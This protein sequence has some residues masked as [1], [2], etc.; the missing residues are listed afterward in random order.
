MIACITVPYFAASVERRDD[1]ALDGRS[2]V[3]GGQPWEPRPVFAYSR[4]VA[5]EGVRP[6][7]SL[8]QAHALSPEALF[9]S[10]ARLRYHHA[11]GEVVD[12]LADF[13]GV[14][15]P[16]EVWH[17]HTQVQQSAS[18]AGRS[19][20]AHFYLDLDLPEQEALALARHVGRTVRQE[21]RL[22]PA[23]GLA[24][25]KFAAQV[26]AT[27]TRPNHA[28]P[29]TVDEEAEFLAGRSISFLPLDKEAK[30]RLHLL[31]IRTLGHFGDLPLASL[32]AHFGAG[33]E[34]LYRLA[35]GQ[36]DVP[37]RPPAPELTEQ[38]ARRF[39]YPI[40]DTVT[41]TAVLDHLAAELAG[42]LQKASLAGSRLVLSWESEEGDA[43]Q[44]TAGLRQPTA[45]AG[46]LAATLQEWLNQVHFSSGVTSLTL[47]MP[48][49]APATARQLSLFPLAEPA[50]R[51]RGLAQP[52]A[53]KYDNAGFYQASLADRRH[54][55]PERRFQMHSL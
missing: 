29:V 26:A 40:A 31:G 12:V 4:E 44:H 8:R 11:S 18:A 34:P 24:P 17:S 25:H 21:T 16:E 37:L 9:L 13:A 49:L 53:V 19:L 50:A 23:I 20:P 51:A 6:G 48:G 45:D 47:A 7:M 14:V 43:Y 5:R 46:R 27:L 3:I 35:K 28:R 36:A 38:V 32:R 55:L 41:L 22:A 1:T 33:V 39:D 2:L 10:A 15:E 42:R 30:R 54:P 52:L